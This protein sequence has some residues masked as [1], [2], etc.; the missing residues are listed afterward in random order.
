MVENLTWI[1]LH[2]L[3]RNMLVLMDKQKT[4]TRT[5]ARVNYKEL[6][7][8]LLNFKDLQHDKSIRFNLDMK[9]D[10]IVLKLW[11]VK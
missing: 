6:L 5:L 11:R 7:Q 9:N 1:E 3:V 4:V 8:V 2:D 10:R